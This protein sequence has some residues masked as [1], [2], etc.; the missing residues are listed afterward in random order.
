MG[1]RVGDIIKQMRKTRVSPKTK[2]SELE[3]NDVLNYALDSK[4]NYEK[5]GAWRMRKGRP[6]FKDQAPR[7]VDS[8]GREGVDFGRIEKKE[9]RPL[10]HFHPKGRGWWPSPEDLD[11]V[12]K[13]PHVIVT[14]FGFWSFV[15]TD[16][17]IPPSKIPGKEMEHFGKFLGSLHLP[18][19]EK[20]DIKKF[21]E[22][23]KIA[24]SAIIT[25][26]KFLKSYGITIKF[27]SSK[28]SLMK[29]LHKHI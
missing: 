17:R 5:G 22:H 27:Y 2:N 24:K 13:K 20:H 25:F 7:V 12:N 9:I 11:L 14:R 4:I 23:M 6:L 21:K 8:K 26:S 18:H 1:T 19:W 3:L 29:F 16:P 10:W 28:Q 15:K